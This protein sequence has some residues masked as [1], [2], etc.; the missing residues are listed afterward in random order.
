MVFSPSGGRKYLSGDEFC[1]SGFRGLRFEISGKDWPIKIVRN[2]YKNISNPPHGTK[3]GEFETCIVKL[4][5]SK[6][7][8]ETN[9]M[10]LI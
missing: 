1:S 3:S 10:P 9:K 4:I 8:K 2:N 6:V 7:K 5:G